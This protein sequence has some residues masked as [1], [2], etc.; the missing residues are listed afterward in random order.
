MPVINSC[1]R[2]VL[3]LCLLLF[4]LVLLS[5]CSQ[6]ENG[7]KSGQQKFLVRYEAKGTFASKCDIF[8][9]TRNSEVSADEENEGGVS[10]QD[11]A[12]LPWTL[13]FEVTVTKLR[14]FNT[15]VSA[16]CADNISRSAE[17]MIFIDDVE[18]ARDSK[19]GRTVNAGAEYR[20][21]LE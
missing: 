15:L 13:S 10:L 12:S 17:V 11:K 1:S 9:I 20:L 3:S 21:K 6:P 19:T 18:K 8:Y 4:S 7:A 14:P 5:G 2:K 16:V